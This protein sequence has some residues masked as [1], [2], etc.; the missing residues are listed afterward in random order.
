MWH[1]LLICRRQENIFSSLRVHKHLLCLMAR[2]A[3]EHCEEK[4]FKPKHER[5]FWLLQSAAP[6][7]QSKIQQ[8]WNDS[9]KPSQQRTR[10]RRS[11]MG[12]RRARARLSLLSIVLLF[13]ITARCV[14]GSKI[15]VYNPL[16]WQSHVNFLSSLVGYLV[17]EG[18]QV[19][20]SGGANVSRR[21]FSHLSGTNEFYWMNLCPHSRSRVLQT[22]I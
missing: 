18:H 16:H 11:L 9:F 1:I 10:N 19:V 6:S 13:L 3:N 2:S 17:D 5:P 20:S 12:G 8:W 15:L 14:S 22:P 7:R 4:G 21:W